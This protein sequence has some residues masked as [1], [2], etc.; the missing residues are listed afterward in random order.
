MLVSQPSSIYSLV[1]FTYH[2][3]D[4][5]TKALDRREL[6]SA[7]N[8][9]YREDKGLREAARIYNIPVETL[10]RHV[11]GSV[12]VGAKPGPA[13]IL[14]DEEEDTLASYIVQMTDMGFCMTRETVMKLAFAIVE[15]SKKESISWRQ[16]WAFLVLWFPEASYSFD[17]AITTTILLLSSPFC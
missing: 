2:I 9:N 17:T 15:E 11:N 6:A 3:L 5:Q 10:I 7:I 16:N 14:T 12:E 13:S 8:S 1:L 4:V